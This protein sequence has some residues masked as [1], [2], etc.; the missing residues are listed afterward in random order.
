MPDHRYN[1]G[2][3]FAAIAEVH[4][5]RKAMVWPE[6][7]ELTYGQLHDHAA[8]IAVRLMDA[9]IVKGDVVAI[10]NAKSPMSM[11][12]ILRRSIVKPRVSSRQAAPS[13]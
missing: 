2:L 5:A 1:L 11:C 10:V 3:A 4:G 13:C 6:G 8:R 12:A 7:H 9:G